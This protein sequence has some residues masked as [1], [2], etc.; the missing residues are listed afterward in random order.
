MLYYRRIDGYIVGVRWLYCKRIHCYIVEG[1]MVIL[2]DTLLY[3][4]KIDGYIVGYK[5][6]ILYEDT[7]LY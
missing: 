6:A 7:W 4:R 3:C 5:M 1:L 2:E